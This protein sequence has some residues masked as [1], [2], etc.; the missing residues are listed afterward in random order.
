[1]MVPHLNQQEFNV[2]KKTLSESKN[3]L[4]YGVGGSTVLASSFPLESIISVDSD[5]KWIDK[6][7]SEIDDTGK[8]ISLE[9]CDIG[10]VRDWGIPINYNGFKNYWKYI[11]QPWRI[12]KINQIIP[13]VILIDGRFRVACFLYTLTKVSSETVILFDDY[14]NRTEYSTIERFLMPIATHGHMAEFKGGYNLDS[15]ILDYILQYSN[16]YE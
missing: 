15:E 2:L 1:M 7:K 16:N 6:V 3:Y 4:E 11:T 10:E 8:F 14:T 12:A 9:Y 13:D 5:I